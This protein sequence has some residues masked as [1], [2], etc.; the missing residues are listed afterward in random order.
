L[1]QFVKR[2]RKNY[3]AFLKG[4]R[5]SLNQTKI[6][7][8]KELGFVFSIRTAAPRGSKKNQMINQKGKYDNAEDEEVSDE[9]NDSDESSVE[10]YERPRKIAR[11]EK[12]PP[13]LSQ[14][15]IAA[16]N[17]RWDFAPPYAALAP[18]NH[19]WDRYDTSRFL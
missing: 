5:T 11:Q 12:P 10:E 15:K 18:Q 1:G 8:L 16:T 14:A 4:Q 6:N 17:D 2:I 7:R 19:P 13:Y 3:Q 9:S